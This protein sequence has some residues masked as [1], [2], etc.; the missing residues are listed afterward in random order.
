MPN[1]INSDSAPVLRAYLN[2][3]VLGVTGAGA[4]YTVLFDTVLEGSGYSTSTGLYTVPLTGNYIAITNLFFNNIINSANNNLSNITANGVSYRLS[5]AAMAVI[6][7][8]SSQYV[9][10]GAVALNMTAGQTISTIATINNGTLNSVGLSGGN[11]PNLTW[12][13]IKYLP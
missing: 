5:E 13:F 3:P 4:A 7:D 1:I 12:L 6:K 2:T 9:V 8:A 10:N 11:S